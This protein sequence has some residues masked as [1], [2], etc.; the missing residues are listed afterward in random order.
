[1]K[2]QTHL[3]ALAALT[4]GIAT[5]PAAFAAG[6]HDHSPKHGGVVAEGK[7]FDAELVAKQDLITVHFSD[8]GKPMMT[9]G[10][11]GKI[12]LLTGGEKS[13]FEL[14]PAGDSRM[15]AKGKFNVAKGTK[16]VVEVT[17]EGKKPATVRFAIK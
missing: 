3:I 2:Q 17:L 10:A 14:M 4:L 12:T 16:A 5:A 6:N 15:E 8:H 9:K 7:A 11:K 1:M 13:E